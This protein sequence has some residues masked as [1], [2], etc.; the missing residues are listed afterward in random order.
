MYGC[1]MSWCAHA[2]D[3]TARR[4][5][6]QLAAPPLTRGYVC[7]KCCASAMAYCS[8]VQRLDMRLATTYTVFF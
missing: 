5:C 8:M 1:H 7:T 2:G 4:P 6:Q 3:S